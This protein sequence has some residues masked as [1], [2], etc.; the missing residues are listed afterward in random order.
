MSNDTQPNNTPSGDQNESNKSNNASENVVGRDMNVYGDEV[1]GDNVAGSKITAEN[2]GVAANQIGNSLV[3]TGDYNTVNY[4]RLN[5]EDAR[6]QRNHKMLRQMVRSFWVDGV[7]KSSLYNEVLIRLNLEKKPDAVDNRPWD[8]ILKQPGGPDFSIPAGTP[9]IDVFDQMNGLLLILGE[10]GSGKT[11]TLLELADELLKRA[12]EDPTHPTPVVFN[13]SSWAEKQQ[14]LAD[15]LVEEIRTKYNIPK[16]LAQKWVENDELLPLLDGLDEVRQG[17]RED[18]VKTINRYRQE[19]LV[20]IAVCSRVSE[21]EDLITKLKL[22]GA[23]LLHPLT[24][25]QIETYLHEFSYG[26]PHVMTWIHGDTELKERMRSP[27]M[28]TIMVL[29]FQGTGEEEL[30]VS[31]LFSYSHPQLFDTYIRRM[32]IHRIAQTEYTFTIAA[33]WLRWLASHLIQN[34]QSIFLIERMQP[35][36]LQTDEQKSSQLPVVLLLAGPIYGLI[37]GFTVGVLGGMIDGPIYGFSSALRNG[38]VS[39]TCGGLVVGLI[40]SLVEG[41]SGRFKSI[42][43]IEQSTTLQRTLKSGVYSALFWGIFVGLICGLFA[44][45]TEGINNGIWLGLIIGQ[46]F[47]LIGGLIGGFREIE[48]AKYTHQAG[49]RR[50]KNLSF[51][52]TSGLIVGLCFGLFSGLVFALSN[53][54]I[55][56]PIAILIAAS[57]LGL[58]VGLS[59]GL[60]IG[61]L[62]QPTTRL[63]IAV[64]KEAQTPNQG[65]KLS[66]NNC[67][68]TSSVYGLSYGLIFGLVFWPSTGLFDALL[69]GLFLGLG[70][71]LSMGLIGG[72]IAVTKHTILRLILWWKGNIPWNYAKFL[73][74]CHERI[75]LR[76]VGGGYIFIHRMLMEHFAN[77]TDEDIE[78]IANEVE[79]V[80]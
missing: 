77:M 44:I 65:I 21:Y 13:L 73:D 34:G 25:E 1:H 7:L 49:H 27:L 16:R 41:L 78:R 46:I 17:N 56:G 28:L 31:G 72:G 3:I 23:V 22:Q 52:L 33:Q 79:A 71:G 59:G 8:L 10:P 6:N 62:F 50:W 5:P 64:T 32:S 26:L 29:A 76:K 40:A 38:I 53:Q 18:C 58:I 15:W 68:R 57:I 24:W 48:P 19:H 55:V 42:H 30:S 63:D 67:L 47:C 74:Y 75:L 12:D 66:W 4:P 35:N 54:Q 45:W 80:R 69:I 51:G 2:R 11:T 9:I 14:P 20:P 43:P 60:I 36:W 39:G 70:F 37:G 61:L